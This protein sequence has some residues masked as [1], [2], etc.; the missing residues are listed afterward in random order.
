MDP[1]PRSKAPLIQGTINPTRC[2]SKSLSIQIAVNPNRCQ[3]KSLSIQIA[4]NPNR[5]DYFDGAPASNR[6]CGLTASL[7]GLQWTGV[8]TDH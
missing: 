6:R 1:R 7:A 3:S 5:R 8:D 2:Q 4:V